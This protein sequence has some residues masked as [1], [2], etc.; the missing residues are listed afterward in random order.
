MRR[1]ALMLHSALFNFLFEF[2]T[3]CACR[4][5]A[6][7]CEYAGK[8]LSIVQ[9]K[10]KLFASLSFSFA[11][12]LLRS[13]SIMRRAS[14]CA[15]SEHT[16]HLEFR[17]QIRRIANFITSPY[18]T[19]HGRVSNGSDQM[20]RA[21]NTAQHTRSANS[22]LGSHIARALIPGETKANNNAVM[23]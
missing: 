21:L 9:M 10:V 6:R 18:I 20:N 23:A 7:P 8:L 14:M 1:S 4:S 11:F 17:A 13:I 5:V 12:S 16:K 3:F 2:H 22:W 15:R 19:Y